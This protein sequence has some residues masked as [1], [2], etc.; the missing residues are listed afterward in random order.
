MEINGVAHTFITVGNFAAARA[1]KR[2]ARAACQL[3]DQSTIIRVR[4]SLTDS[5][6]PRGALPI[7]DITRLA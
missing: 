3:P 1:F 2:P 4:A 6:R 5:S 7:G